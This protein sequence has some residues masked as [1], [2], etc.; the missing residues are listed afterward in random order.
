MKKL[1]DLN[2]NEVEV[3]SDGA[4]F[5][6]PGPGGWAAILLE[7]KKEQKLA[8]FEK[9]TTNNRMELTAVICALKKIPLGYEVRIYSDSQYVTKG[10]TIWM[11]KWRANN[12][13][14]SD[15]KEILNKDLWVQLDKLLSSL[16]HDFVWVKGHSGVNYNEMCNDLAQ[17]QISKNTL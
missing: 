17:Q 14:K 1:E 16:K 6:N 4:C 5:G 8:G 2:M 12:W 10:A 9:F 3:W 13:R 11:P 15:N 7:G